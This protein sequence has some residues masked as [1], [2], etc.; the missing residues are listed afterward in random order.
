MRAAR[1]LLLVFVPLL[2]IAPLSVLAQ[3][4]IVVNFYYPTAVD[5]PIAEIIQ[6]YADQFHELNPNITVNPTYTGSYTQTTQT[7]QTEISGGGAGP[8]VAVMLTTDLL[9]FTEEGVIVPVQD[10]LDAMDDGQAIVDDI[11]PALLLNGEDEDGTIWSMPFQRSTPILFY[12]VDMLSAAGFDEPPKNNEELLTMAEAL[13]KPDG[14]QWGLLVPFA[15]G[16]PIWM[17]QSFAIGYGQNI[18]TNNPTEVFMDDAKV[19][20]ALDFATKLGTDY[21]VG[22]IGGSAWGDTPTA[23][24]SGQAAMIY[25][26]TG[27]LTNILN[28]APFNVGVGFLPSGPAGEDGTGYGTPTGGG[29]LYLFD[30][31][32][33]P[34]SPEQ[35]DAAWQWILYLVSPEIQSDWGAATGYVAAR[36]SAWDL[37]PLKSLADAKPQYYTARDQLAFADREFATY[38]SVDVT[39]II[40]STLSAVLSG[41]ETDAAAAMASAQAQIDS[42]LA[43]YK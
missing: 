21:A 25:H 29:N 24:I 2:L 1:L 34:R 8:D 15:G 41:A 6:R 38:R 19:L 32:D 5:G 12:N 26:T 11:F 9:S 35:L 20:E 30:T 33:N 40:N 17:F 4:Q 31:P 42:L 10:Y 7:I 3:D 14:T 28:N 13:T 43:E 37:D 16:F 36:V 39:T 23:F 27:S 18:G 22:P